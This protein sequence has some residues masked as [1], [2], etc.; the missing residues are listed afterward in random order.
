MTKSKDAPTKGPALYENWKGLVAGTPLLKT[1]EIPLFTDAHITG[2][3]SEGYG[4]YQF[5]NTVPGLG[6]TH[7]LRPSIVW[8]LDT[9][10][11]TERN[12]I[13]ATDEGR[14]HGGW[15]SDEAAA[16]MSLCLGIRVR[17]GGI[18]REFMPNDDP[19]GMPTEW[20]YD[21]KPV[22]I[23]PA[24]RRGLM[25]PA[26]VGT[27]SLDDLAPLAA[28]P[29]LTP[30]E[31]IALIRSARLYQESLWV[32][33]S[34]P[35]LS[36]LLMISA[37]ETAASH[38]REAKDPPLARLQ[39]TMP[40]LE[41]ALMEAG[42]EALTEKIAKMVAPFMGSTKKF[43]DFMIAFIP[44]APVER[45][46]EKGQHSWDAESLR[47][48]LNKIYGYRSRALHGGTPFPAPMC[49][50][51]MGFGE[52]GASGKRVLEEVPVGN[53]GMLGST[54]VADDIPMYLHVF[55]HIVRNA[56][57]NWWNSMT[58]PTALAE[59]VEDAPFET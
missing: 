2:A 36:W 12:D 7:A 43:L 13:D 31:S 28:L 17:P 53:I 55:E 6:D 22:L 38:W 33:E 25:V 51:A 5:L 32:A 37:I 27:H 57:R 3:I 59:P 48:S 11:E 19:K 50:P 10:I 41:T 42:G 45:P 56:L 23:F 14:Y 18:T 58:P 44:D 34:E 49:S 9:Y 29:Q 8:R 26:A 39:A 46:W 35:N 16:L 40:K 4:P 15:L 24:F 21:E 20:A 54:W 47:A 1:F 52:I 30:T